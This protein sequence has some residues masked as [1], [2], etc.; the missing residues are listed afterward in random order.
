ME[1]NN[2]FHETL[3]VLNQIDAR[4]G[5]PEEI[6]LAVSTL[7]PIVNVDLLIS[8]EKG[9]ILLSWRDDNCFGKGW[10]IPGGCIRFMETMEER[11]QKTAMQELGTN[12]IFDSEPLA[13]KDVI[14]KY[15]RESAENQKYRAHHLAILYKCSLPAGFLVEN[16]MLREND[17]GYLK[18]FEKLPDDLLP[19]HDVYLDIL[20]NI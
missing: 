20:K 14:I 17:A 4:E 19:V 16:G 8:D 5:L 18:W 3:E 10:H 6:F 12:V 9:R 7:V 13:V 11:I 15:Y 1:D 2:K